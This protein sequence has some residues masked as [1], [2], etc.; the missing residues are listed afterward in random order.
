[1]AA[2]RLAENSGRAGQWLSSGPVS[3]DVPAAE[4]RLR[5][6]HLQGNRVWTRTGVYA[7]VPA[8]KDRNAVDIG[9][10]GARR[11]EKNGVKET[12][13]GVTT[14]KPTGK[15]T[16][17]KGENSNKGRETTNLR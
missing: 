14:A 4:P 15:T 5:H 16:D 7:G 1:M 17:A 8:R 2:T 13:R 11:K 6:R 9:K 12:K 3:A 10:S